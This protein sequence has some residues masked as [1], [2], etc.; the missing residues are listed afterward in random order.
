MF[1]VNVEIGDGDGGAAGDFTLERQA[2]L[3]HARS[4]EVGGEGGNVIGDAFGEPGGETAR[5]G[6]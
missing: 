4:H 5:R 3:L 6:G 2:G 1:A